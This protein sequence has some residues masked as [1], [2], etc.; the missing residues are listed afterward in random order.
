MVYKPNYLINVER[1]RDLVNARKWGIYV[2]STAIGLGLFISEIQRIRKLPFELINFGYMALFFMTVFLIFSWIWST[3]KEF[4]LLLKWSDP[5]RYEPPSGIKETLIIL[6]LAILLVALLF[7]SRNP[8][9]YSS[10]FSVYSIFNLYG[11]RRLDKELSEVFAKSKNRARADIDNVC[12]AEKA[13][14][15]I[16]V[17][18]NIEFY[19]MKRPH[20]RRLVL[21]LICSVAA[22][23]LSICWAISKATILGFEAYILFLV[24]LI[25]SEFTISRWRSIRDAELR[26]VIAELNELIRT[27]NEDINARLQKP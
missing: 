9:W 5:E 18:E 20:V 23:G 12:F 19:F 26:P 16:K 4:D 21:V 15:Y 25:I 7:A 14:L 11:L 24:T 22:L 27:S 13:K 6:S 1:S 8:L 3:Q 10:I 2:I 17:V